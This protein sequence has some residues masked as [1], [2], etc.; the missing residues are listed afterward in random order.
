MAMR[1]FG[2]FCL[3]GRSTIAL[4]RREVSRS[5]SRLQKR[6]PPL[7]TRPRISDEDDEPQ[8]F[9]EFVQLDPNAAQPITWYPGHIAKAEKAL[10]E[11]LKKVDV[12][13]EVRDGRIPLSTTHPMVPE[14]V[15][16]KPLIIAVAR[17]DQISR[18]ALDGWKKYYSVTPPH[19]TRPDAKVFF[20]DG[21]L[22]AGILPLKK[23]A[24]K[25]GVALNERYSDI[26]QNAAHSQIKE[27]LPL[28][29]KSHCFR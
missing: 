2:G 3:S 14:W 4:A 15:G 6:V 1:N 12:V 10:A 19:P 17:I 28:N 25:A 5:F 13:I 26:S 29:Y 21:K 8:T 7:R 11:Y 16:S 24:L 27:N 22:G 23:E 9:K 20:I 18:K